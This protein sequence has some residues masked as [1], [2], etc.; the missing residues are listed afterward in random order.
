MTALTLMALALDQELQARGVSLCRADCE[1]IIEM[2]IQRTAE[3]AEAVKK[4]S[5]EQTSTGKLH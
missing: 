1:A 3:A 2:V 5:S 4:P